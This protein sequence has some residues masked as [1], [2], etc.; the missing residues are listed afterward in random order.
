MTGPDLTADAIEGFLADAGAVCRFASGSNAFNAWQLGRVLGELGREM[1]A[2]V[3]VLDAKH[4][5]ADGVTY[6][7]Q[8][9]DDQQL[10]AI[11]PVSRTHD[12]PTGHHARENAKCR[13]SELT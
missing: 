13:R 4:L 2:R 8:A 6:Q 10:V 3:I 12:A 1:P 5:E 9:H 11:I 7:I